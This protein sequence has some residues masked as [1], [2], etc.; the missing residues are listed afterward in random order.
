M[1]SGSIRRAKGRSGWEVRVDAGR[2]PVTGR[3]RQ[4]SRSLPTKREAEAVLAR[5]VVEAGGGQHGGSDAAFAELL[6]SW[7]EMRSPDWS[8]KTVLEHRRLIDRS[9]KPA[10]GAVPLRKL[11]SEDLDRFYARLRKSGS[12][13]GKPLKASSVRRVHVVVH[14]ALEQAL[15]WRWIPFNP[16]DAASPPTPASVDIRPPSPEGVVRLIEIATEAE[17]EFGLFLRLAAVTGARRGALC[18]LRYSDFDMGHRRVTI[19]RGIVEGPDGLVEKDTKT[20]LVQ[21]VAL[22]ERTLELIGDHRNRMAERAAVCGT[23]LGEDAYV[24]SYDPACATP[25]RPDGITSRFSRVRIAA[26]LPKTR[27]HDLRHWVGTQLGDAGV[28]I[29]TISGRLGHSRNSTTLDMYTKAIDATDEVAAR[30]LAGLLDQQ[31]EA[32][33]PAPAP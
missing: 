30:V 24:F 10:L 28:P 25:W 1:A 13:Q 21:R 27:V 15:K 29:A 23:A 12:Q 26:G 3:R 8:P 33:M 32:F 7:F 5:L 11:R 19:G 31:A 4:I 20:H 9:I 6:E 17:P 22:D 16:A 18:A 14:S 2:D